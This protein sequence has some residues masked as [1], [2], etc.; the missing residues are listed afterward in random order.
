MCR[1]HLAAERKT[2]MKL[3]LRPLEGAD[4][5]YRCGR[6]FIFGKV[7]KGMSTYKE[8]R[9]A[10]LGVVG[11]LER[12]EK[13]APRRQFREALEGLRRKLEAENFHV[14]IMGQFKRGKTTFINGVL[15]AEVLP[16]SVVPLT[17][18]NTIL[19]YG[20]RVEAVV[21]YLDGRR[22][23]VSVAD[24][25]SYVT[26][27]G[28]PEN[29]LKVR[30]VEVFYPSPFL[31]DGLCLV[32]TPGTGST[33]LH[34]DET[35]YS[36]LEHA[37]AVIFMLSADPPVSRAELDFLRHVRSNVRKIFFVQNKIDYLDEGEA[38]ESLA[39]NRSV[40]AGAMGLDDV[41]IHPLSAKLALKAA[42]GG[43]GSLLRDSGL[44][45]FIT[46][47]GEF[48]MNEK[49]RLLLESSARRLLKILDDEYA[50]L[51]LE[52]TLL[53]HPRDELQG[54]VASFHEQMEVV[55]REGEEL[56]IL[57]RGDHERL[58]KEVLDQEIER[59]KERETAPLL[60][61][62]DLFV[63]EN[64]GLSGSALREALATYIREEIRETFTDWRHAME[65][66]LSNAFRDMGRIYMEKANA[67]ANRILEI[68]GDL[69]G[70]TLPR[71]ETELILSDEGE[72][73]FKMEDPL[74]DLEVIFGVISRMLPKGLSRRL[75]KKKQREE[76]L[77]LF[78]RHC[79]RVRYD[80]FLRLQKSMHALSYRV[81]EVIRETMEAIQTGIEKAVRQLDEG[82]EK[83]QEALEEIRRRQGVLSA[84]RERVAKTMKDIT[85]EGVAP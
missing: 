37:D 3:A 29:R 41:A 23:E 45:Y 72:F 42:V 84:A 30:Y 18:I 8:I 46:V 47:L 48:L 17:S 83:H 81:E 14:V 26:E 12:E 24:L 63:E 44:P 31:R 58:V 40:I 71:L 82:A 61:R 32:D 2:A 77:T 10:L 15:G 53:T 69:F 35:A 28:N 75:V 56:R 13:G 62:F 7:M 22:E 6:S 54:K 20:D 16:S 59:F 19:R 52:M 11:E 55:R 4:S 49:G 51:E 5:F 36:F 79:G 27:K 25:H 65:E 33:Y 34:N 50:S 78:D 9:E 68:A 21:H 74:T 76:L 38:R 60:Q 67:I 57:I 66:R 1:R 80:F 85:G 64:A 70:I 39:F 73:W 43:D